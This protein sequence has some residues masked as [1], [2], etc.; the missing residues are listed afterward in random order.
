[1]KFILTVTFSWEAGSCFDDKE[2]I[3]SNELKAKTIQDA[4]KKAE[5]L[6]KKIIREKAPRARDYRADAELQ[7]VVTVWKDKKIVG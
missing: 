6:F 4:K 3:I 7:Q 1:M 5:A 2:K